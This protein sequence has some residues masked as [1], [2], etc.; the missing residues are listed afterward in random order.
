MQ[1]ILKSSVLFQIFSLVTGLNSL[2][3]NLIKRAPIVKTNGY[4]RYVKGLEACT[5][6][7][8]VI[9]GRRNFGSPGTVRTC[10]ISVNSGKLYQLSYRGINFKLIGTVFRQLV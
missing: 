10:D 6:S 2:A 3:T 9:P 8:H 4:V 1:G 5:R 7:A